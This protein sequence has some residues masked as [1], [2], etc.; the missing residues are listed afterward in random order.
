[1][2]KRK[3]GRGLGSLLENALDETG[4]VIELDIKAKEE[5]WFVSKYG[6]I[7]LPSRKKD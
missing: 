3:L 5:N 7:E 2:V 6:V 4:K 1:M